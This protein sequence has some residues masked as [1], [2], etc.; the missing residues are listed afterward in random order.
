MPKSVRRNLTDRQ[1]LP[2]RQRQ[3]GRF[4]LLGRDIAVILV[5]KFAVLAGLW[6]VFFSHP[7]ARHMSVEPQRVDAHLFPSHSAGS[8][9]E[10][11]RADR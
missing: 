5:V 1:T 3:R 10:P 6:W 11:P 9:P 4:S 2:Q 8:A 7:V